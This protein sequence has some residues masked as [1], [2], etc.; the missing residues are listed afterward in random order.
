MSSER[1]LTVRRNLLIPSEVLA[2]L[3]TA[4]MGQS[5]FACTRDFFFFSWQ[6]VT[7]D[8][9]LVSGFIERYSLSVERSL[10]TA[11]WFL[12]PTASRVNFWLLTR[13]SR[14]SFSFPSWV[15]GKT[16]SPALN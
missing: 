3:Q 14:A 16:L 8:S 12:A 15:V 4:G 13:R 2:G 5:V 7:A 6:T 1:V 9:F 10:H 11:D